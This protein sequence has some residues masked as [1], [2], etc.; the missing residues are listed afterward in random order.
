MKKKDLLFAFCVCASLL[1]AFPAASQ[2]DEGAAQEPQAAKAEK[3][4]ALAEGYIYHGPDEAER[5]KMLFRNEALE[6]GHAYYI[7]LFLLST[8]SANSAKVICGLFQESSPVYVEYASQQVKAEVAEKAGAVAA[9]F[10]TNL[11]LAV[12]VAGGEPPLHRPIVLG[13][14][15]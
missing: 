12:V 7:D 14:A 11:P 9:L 4:A 2:A 1:C 10:G 6:P 13:V 3:A 15:E 8:Y 5:N